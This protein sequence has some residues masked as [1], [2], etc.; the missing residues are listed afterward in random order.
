MAVAVLGV[1]LFLLITFSLLFLIRAGVPG[2]GHITV[3]IIADSINPAGHRL[4]TYECTFNRYLLAELNTHRM[5]SRNSASSRAIPVSRTLHQVWADPAVPI[6]WGAN[7]A[8]MQARRELVGWRR[9]VAVRLFLWARVPILA[10]VWMLSKVGLHKQVAN[11][12]LEPWIWHTAVISMTEDENFFKLRDHEDAQ[13]EFRVLARR[14]REARDASSPRPVDWGG[15][16]TPYTD[17]QDDVRRS[18]LVPFDHDHTVPIR[19]WISCAR[20]AAVSYVR[21]GEKRDPTKD[22]DL[23]VRLRD[24]GHWSPFEHVAQAAVDTMKP[25]NFRGW[26][27]LRK[28]Y[29][30]E[31]G[32][33][34]PDTDHRPEQC[35]NGSLYGCERCT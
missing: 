31:D 8:G 33:S 27:Q 9:W 6:S 16:H 18:A 26:K 13:P 15:W 21:Q 2:P 35:P 10:I 20:C 34:L 22:I 23:T 28:F 32:R 25:S 29:P 14:M 30:G 12:L 5:L 7:Q 1:S 11:R 17:E 3:R 19:A 4:T 24:G